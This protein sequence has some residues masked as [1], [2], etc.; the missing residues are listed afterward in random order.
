MLGGEKVRNATVL[1]TIAV[2][3]EQAWNEKFYVYSVFASYWMGPLLEE[4]YSQ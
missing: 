4:Q 3:T 1:I 2:D